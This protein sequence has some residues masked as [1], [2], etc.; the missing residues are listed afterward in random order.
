MAPLGGAEKA[1]LEAFFKSKRGAKSLRAVVAAALIEYFAN[2]GT[3]LP[4]LPTTRPPDPSRIEEWVAE[5]RDYADAAKVGDTADVKNVGRWI[6]DR[7]PARL[8]GHA[9][10]QC[11]R[12]A[13]CGEPLEFP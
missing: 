11:M 3:T 12:H 13:A 9:R 5:W 4:E 8:S 2:N 7:A 10:G 1:A 6:A